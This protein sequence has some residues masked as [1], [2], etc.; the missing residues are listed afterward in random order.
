MSLGAGIYLGIWGQIVLEPMISPILSDDS[1]SVFGAIAGVQGSLLG[2]VLAALTIVLGFSQSPQFKL[3]K[4]SG[5]LPTLFNVYMAGIRAHTLSTIVALVALLVNSANALAP[6][7]A[8]LVTTTCVLAF[9][10][11]ARTLW[12]TKNVVWILASTF[13][14]KPGQK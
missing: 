13:E 8:W 1:T 9:V 4:D 7:L 11:L 6:V 12:A 10:R 3:L 14:R 2:F 5:H